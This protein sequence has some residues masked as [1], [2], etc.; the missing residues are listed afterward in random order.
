MRIFL[1]G[2]VLALL[3]FS[4]SVQSIKSATFGCNDWDVYKR[5]SMMYA[6]GD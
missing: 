3:P 5:I 1:I 4:A 2:L 6:Q